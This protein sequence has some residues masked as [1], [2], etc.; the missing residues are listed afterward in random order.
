MILYA[1][2]SSIVKLYVEEERFQQTRDLT[3]GAGEI[4]T[5]I[6]AYVEMRSALA[7][8][9]RSN[10]IARLEYNQVLEDFEHDWPLYTIIP[11]SQELASQA[12]NLAERHA[13]RALDAIHLAS[14]TGLAERTSEAVVFL[15]ADAV[16]LTAAAQEGLATA[17]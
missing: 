8:K 5:S 15:S 13:L 1:D 4:T 6:I 12:G 16:L 11:V 14:A 7:R 17:A 9:L 3:G 2:T 10:E